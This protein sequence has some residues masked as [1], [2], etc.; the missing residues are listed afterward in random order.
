MPAGDVHRIRSQPA[1]FDDLA[2]IA[3]CRLD[4]FEPELF[5]IEMPDT[6][7]G[8]CEIKEPVRIPLMQ[9]LKLNRVPGVPKKTS[10]GAESHRVPG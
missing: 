3:F 9:G 7:A 8:D 6:K 1:H 10:E 4:H 2:G 5:N